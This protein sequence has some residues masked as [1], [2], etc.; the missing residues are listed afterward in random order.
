MSFVDDSYLYCKAGVSEAQKIMKT[1]AKFE[2]VS[3]LKVN[4][5]K[6]SIFFGTNTKV[7]IRQILYDALQIEEAHEYCL[8]LVA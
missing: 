6:S 4:R 7:D 8:Y 5:S 1:L 3:G 2:L